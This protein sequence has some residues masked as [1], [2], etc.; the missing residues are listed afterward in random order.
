MKLR[1]NLVF[2][3]LLVVTLV[4]K[5]AY[6]QQPPIEAP[7]YKLNGIKFTFKTAAPIR[8]T[9]AISGGVLYFG[10][11]DD[12]FYAVDGQSGK[13]IWRFKTE[14]AIYSSP[15]INNG[16]AYFSSR[17][18]YIYALQSSSGKE[19]WKF[20]MENDLGEENFWD[21]YLSSPVIV[22]QDLF[23]GSGDGN[24]Y[25]FNIDAK[26]LIWKY[27]TG[28]RIKTTPAVYEG[29]VIFGTNAGFLI[30][31]SKDKGVLQ[32]KFATDGTK[33]KF[34]DQNNDRTSIFCSP[35]V[36]DGMVVTGGR[37]GIIYAVDLSTGKE[38]WRVDHKGPWILSTAIKDGVVFVACGSDAM[39]QALDLKTGNEKWQF[40]SRDANFSSITLAG[41][42][43]YFSDF[44]GNVH[45]LSRKTGAENWCFPMGS[46]AFS[47]PV[48]SDGIVYCSSDNGIL[49]ALQGNPTS[50]PAT[51]PTR[52]IVYWEPKKTD[53]A[54]NYF[55]DGI[56]V[57]IKE[58]FVLNGYELMNAK[59]LEQVINDQLNKK[60]T[61][62][63]VFAGNM[64]PA[65]IGVL[66]SDKPLIR[67]YLDAGGK[68][69]IF[70]INPISF[71]L[72]STTGQPT[73]FDYG[74]AEK[75][76][77]LQFAKK[78]FV[79]GYYKAQPTNEGKK[80]GLYNPWFGFSGFTAIIPDPSIK[81]LASDE[82]GNAVAWIKNYG[83]PDGTG[84]LQL[85]IPLSEACTNLSEIKTAIEY[86]AAW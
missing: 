34:E 71:P 16:V 67:K 51:V 58:Y 41:D 70:G 31:L 64:V 35:S 43:L 45:A 47:A 79:G 54:F 62:L 7:V 17:D 76:L 28:A 14:G 50:A 68:A 63:V 80:D 2:P 23:I 11:G 57:Y 18:K 37:D 1:S 66:N 52:K 38:K 6:A 8:S 39:L 60:S 42:M 56:E 73:A 22:G 49:Y 65:N 83:G 20:R 15:A 9:A 82:F 53:S 75:A 48:V 36:Q 21:N 27:N 84:L 59:Q 30:C 25:A 78:K 26:Q 29:Q 81:V 46:R 5:S 44:S 4:I 72:D 86:G 69:A 61:S 3:F 19:L 55:L 74:I 32:W 24:L 85:Y 12:Y 33:N 13:Q 40:K 77:G 10:G